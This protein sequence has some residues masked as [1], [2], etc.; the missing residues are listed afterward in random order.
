[1]NSILCYFGLHDF[2]IDPT[3]SGRKFCYRCG[4][5]SLLLI[6]SGGNSY[7]KNISFPDEGF[8]GLRAK[9]RFWLVR[10]L[11]NDEALIRAELVAT[12]KEF[13]YETTH[14]SPVEDNGSHKC[15][16]SKETLQRGRGILARVDAHRFERRNR[17]SR[18]A[19][20]L[21]RLKKD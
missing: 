5:K 4:M 6:R 2:V 7:W 9:F 10:W 11:A 17:W 20:D 16:I 21:I 19:N 14:M 15:S 8:W 12:L 18:V 13:I 1:M 3:N